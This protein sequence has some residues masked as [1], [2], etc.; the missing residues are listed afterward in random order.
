VQFKEVLL[1]IVYPNVTSVTTICN[2][3]RTNPAEIFQESG[4]VGRR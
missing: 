1:M 3:C 2:R 4:G